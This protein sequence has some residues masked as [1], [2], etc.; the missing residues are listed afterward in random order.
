M[1]NFQQESHFAGC[2]GRIQPESPEKSEREMVEVMGW[3]GLG[4]DYT[5]LEADLD[6]GIEE[7]QKGVEG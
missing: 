5:R 3:W 6:L 4:F 1:S 7:H 2:A